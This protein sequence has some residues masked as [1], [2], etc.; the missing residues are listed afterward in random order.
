MSPTI[1]GPL[2]GLSAILTFACAASAFGQE[3]RAPQQR[4][5]VPPPPVS[6]AVPSQPARTIQTQCEVLEYGARCGDLHVARQAHARP[7]YCLISSNSQSTINY[8]VG[9]Y[10]TGAGG[11]PGYFMRI[12]MRDDH[13]PLVP[14]SGDGTFSVS[15]GGTSF[16]GRLRRD[17]APFSSTVRATFDGGTGV[18]L[19][20]M[21]LDAPTPSRPVPVIVQGGR[22][23]LLSIQNLA[24]AH[25]FARGLCQ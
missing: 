4:T 14:M 19:V 11:S 18:A 12:T 15:I 7:V 2:I 22:T 24:I 23:A 16:E 25:G 8:E 10:P 1:I 3:E 5:R 13:A 21:L 9:Y 20:R 6:Q 17:P